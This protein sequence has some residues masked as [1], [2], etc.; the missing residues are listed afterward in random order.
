MKMASEKDVKREIKKL[1]D[2]H[3]WFWFM[4]PA[5]G[6]GKAGVSDVI[7]LKNGVFL[8]IEAKYG[9][10]KPSPAQKA[11]VESVWAQ[12]GMGFVV[13]DKNIT[14]L[15]QW[16]AAFDRSVAAVQGSAGGD[17]RQAVNQA[18]GALMLNAVS[19][20]TELCK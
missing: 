9:G 16:L 10:N 18:D 8:A 5:N 14:W 20:L 17:P 3:D 11:F 13:N 7:A 6:Y 15:E 12:H 2:A 4:P 19:V 1:L